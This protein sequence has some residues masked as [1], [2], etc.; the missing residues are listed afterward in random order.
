MPPSSSPSN[1]FSKR[2]Y[3][4]PSEASSAF[5]PHLTLLVP[6]PPSTSNLSPLFPTA[7]HPSPT[8][9][10]PCN[11]PGGEAGADE[12][13]HLGFDTLSFS[14]DGQ[15]LVTV[16]KEPGRVLT[17]WYWQQAE[18]TS[19]LAC[20]SACVCVCVCVFVCAACVNLFACA[21]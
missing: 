11:R 8:P 3:L 21:A 16:S 10:L 18:G 7:S 12:V 15:F 9:S 19:A 20:Q 1:L 17:V 4:L 5:P 2:L 14:A 13:Q 6:D